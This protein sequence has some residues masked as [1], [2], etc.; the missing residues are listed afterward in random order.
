MKDY[1]REL[2]FAEDRLQKYV[3]KRDEI[4]SLYGTTF[5]PKELENTIIEAQNE[6]YAAKAA[7]EAQL[8]TNS[9]CATVR[10]N[11]K[12]DRLV[13][14]R[15]NVEFYRSR[16]SDGSSWGIAFISTDKRVDCCIM[17]SETSGSATILS[18]NPAEKTILNE[19]V[20]D[21]DNARAHEDLWSVMCTAGFDYLQEAELKYIQT[22]ILIE[23]KNLGYTEQG[24]RPCKEF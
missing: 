1:K 6:A 7:Y 16:K 14:A 11:T 19:Y 2:S 17:M 18:F 10:A 4:I 21:I 24:L 15:N 20:I 9:N 23:L 8:L 13:F 3:A 12:I 22:Q 5:V